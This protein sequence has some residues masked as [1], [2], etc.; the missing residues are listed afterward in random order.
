[1]RGWK[2][3]QNLVLSCGQIDSLATWVSSDK[4][5][6]PLLHKRG[7]T[8][9]LCTAILED[10]VIGRTC[11]IINIGGKYS[12][13]KLGAFIYVPVI[14]FQIS[15]SDNQIYRDILKI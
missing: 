12:V 15:S 7:I 1:M 8:L 10:G 14:A 5:P 13:V 9:C 4:C 11:T 6:F 2:K 3:C